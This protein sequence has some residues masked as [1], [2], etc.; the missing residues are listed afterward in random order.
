MRSVRRTLTSR[1]LA[2]GRE[3]LEH[4]VHLG[5]GQRLRLPDRERA[6]VDLGECLDLD[7]KRESAR[8]RR[9]DGN[10]SMVGEEARAAS[11]ERGQHMIRQ[12]LRAERRVIGAANVSTAGHGDHVVE[13]GNASPMAGKRGRERRVRV[14]D[15]ARIGPRAIDVAMKPPFG[16]RQA[17]A[18]GLSLEGHRHDVG[19]RRAIVGKPRRRDEETVQVPVTKTGADIAR[20]AAIDPLGIHRQRRLDDRQ[21]QRL[22]VAADAHR[23]LPAHCGLH[24]FGNIAR[25]P[26]PVAGAIPRSVTSPATSLAGVTSNA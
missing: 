3:L 1:G 24:H 17:L 6:P 7:G 11:L 26:A 15:R 22:L 14:H 5:F 23:A 12:R 2:V 8:E 19:R 20:L 21:S 16:R 13:R 25:M 18:A 10:H 9:A 4:D